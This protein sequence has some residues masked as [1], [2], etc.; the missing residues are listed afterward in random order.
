MQR[1]ENNI[2]FYNKLGYFG[3]LNIINYYLSYKI[4][5]AVIYQD[6]DQFLGYLTKLFSFI[7]SVA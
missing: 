1:A 4:Q 6:F 7:H 2:L 3:G 5:R